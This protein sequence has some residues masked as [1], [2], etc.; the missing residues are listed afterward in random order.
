MICLIFF[1]FVLDEMI[2]KNLFLQKISD[3]RI[4]F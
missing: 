2:P 4:H 1:S 3:E